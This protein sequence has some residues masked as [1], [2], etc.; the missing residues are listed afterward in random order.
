M[1]DLLK[2]FLAFLR[3]NRNASPHTVRAYDGDL[4]QLGAY[5][6]TYHA[7]PRADLQPA[8]RVDIQVASRFIK[9]LTQEGDR[10]AVEEHF[11][12]V[13]VVAAGLAGGEG[14]LSKG[15]GAGLE[16]RRLTAPSPCSR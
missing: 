4:S 9:Q 1:K 11:L 13:D 7:R 16:F 8:D 3:L 14:E 10:L 15:D 6:S 2:D 5:L 12:A